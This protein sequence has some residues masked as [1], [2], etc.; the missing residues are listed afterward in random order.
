MPAVDTNGASPPGVP[1]PNLFFINATII[2]GRPAEQPFISNVYVAGGQIV[3]ISSELNPGDYH[4][5]T[6]RVDAEG[7]VLCPGFVDMHAHSDLKLLTEPEHL[8]KVSQGCTVS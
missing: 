4:W 5:G 2:T 6:R 3:E 1:S 7:L 8:A